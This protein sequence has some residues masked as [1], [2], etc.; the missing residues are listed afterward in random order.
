M[1]NNTMFYVNFI[2]AYRCNKL[3]RLV[4]IPSTQSFTPKNL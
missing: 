2:A 4:A 1:K 3:C